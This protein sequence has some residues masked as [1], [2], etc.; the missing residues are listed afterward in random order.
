MTTQDRRYIIPAKDALVR[1]PDMSMT[2]I[3]PEG[4]EVVWSMEWQRAL[5]FGD[6]SIETEAQKAKREQREEQDRKAAEQA[7]RDRQRQE[8][9]AQ[10]AAQADT[11]A[12]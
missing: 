1:D 7:E 9:E 10:K 3:P 4:R 11:K 5:H 2:P 12:G 8:R 6:I